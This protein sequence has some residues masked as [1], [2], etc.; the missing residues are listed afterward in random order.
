LAPLAD[1]AAAEGDQVAISILREAAKELAR[2]AGSAGRLADLEANAFPVVALGGVLLG[3]AHYAHCF[4][5]A[6]VEI[7]PNAYFVSPKKMPVEGAILLALS[8]LDTSRRDPDPN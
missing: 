5:Q 7:S 3:S 8:S 4:R 1:A 6:M 2:V